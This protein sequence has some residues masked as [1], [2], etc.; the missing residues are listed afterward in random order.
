MPD[1][2]PSPGMK[3]WLSISALSQGLQPA[4]PDSIRDILQDDCACEFTPGV[5]DT[6]RAYTKAAKP[7]QQPARATA[8]R[9]QPPGHAGEQ[10]PGCLTL[11]HVPPQVRV[12]RCAA[13]DAPGQAAAPATATT[14]HLPL[15]TQAT[16]ASA[17]PDT[18]KDPTSG[19]PGLSSPAPPAAPP[20]PAT[21]PPPT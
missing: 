4:Y 12:D 13:K 14:G 17:P 20:S 2:P 11:I 15:A 7:P 5:C 19:P 8:D 9:P 10:Q 21:P 18:T 16:P 3:R 6:C 1:P